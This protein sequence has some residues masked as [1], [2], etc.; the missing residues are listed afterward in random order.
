ME[1]FEENATEKLSSDKKRL[2]EKER[3]AALKSVNQECFF[4][5]DVLRD[6]LWLS[7]DAFFGE[8]KETKIVHFTERLRRMERICQDDIEGLILYLRGS[9]RE[10]CE[11]RYVKEDGSCFWCEARGFL[12]RD[13]EEHPKALVG[14]LVDV[15]E[16]KRMH[17]ILI[18]QAW[19]DPL[20]KL[21]C[22]T[23]AQNMIEH[24]LR[25]EG[26]FG[27]HFLMLIDL[28][29]FRAVNKQYGNVFGDSVLVNVGER[30]QKCFRKKDVVARI[31]GDDFLVLLKDIKH[32]DIMERKARQVIDVIK[33]TYC[34]EELRLSCNIGIASFPEDGRNFGS[35]FRHADAA[36]YQSRKLGCNSFEHYD[37]SSQFDEFNKRGE[38]Y[39]E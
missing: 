26:S 32:L 14:C 1:H 21:L 31:G 9:G 18:E 11:F 29:G 12:I 28:C 38:F 25:T 19:L 36:L 5:Y 6:I 39:H 27:R 20:T 16:E 34:G 15:D 35:L 4:E 23:K 24:F 30:I 17:Q 13:E 7:R 2:S 33:N 10:K 37:L 8:F 3:V 22:K